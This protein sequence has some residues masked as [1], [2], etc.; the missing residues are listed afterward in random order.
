MKTKKMNSKLIVRLLRLSIPFI[1]L[2]VLFK[3]MHWPFASG[4]ITIG[5]G[6]IIILYP[7]RFYLKNEK[8][9]I[10][11]VKLVFL[12]SYIV[13]AYLRLFH[14]PNHYLLSIFSFGTFILWITLELFDLYTNRKETDTFKL[15]P[16]GILSV[17]ILFIFMGTF[18]KLFHYPYGNAILLTGFIFLTIY[19]LID[20][21]KPKS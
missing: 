13:N 2:G 9:L 10:D 17:I 19:F 14:L 6:M 21:F 4:L 20:T 12:I 18:Y 3:L 7:I 1:I 11:Y 15:F 16:F 5:F 8:R